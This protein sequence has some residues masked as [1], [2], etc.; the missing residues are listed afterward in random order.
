MALSSPIRRCIRNLPGFSY[1]FISYC[2]HTHLTDRQTD[3][4]EVGG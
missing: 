3:M 1:L 2:L 4:H